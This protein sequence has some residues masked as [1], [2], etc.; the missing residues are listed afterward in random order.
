MLPQFNMENFFSTSLF[1]WGFLFVTYKFLQMTII[2]YIEDITL[3][4]EK[5][6]NNLLKE[7]EDLEKEINNSHKKL[8]KISEELNYEY[9]NAK[10]E[11]KK[12]YREKIVEINE[13]FKKQNK[14][15]EELLKEKIQNQYKNS[16]ISHILAKVKYNSLKDNER[17]NNDNCK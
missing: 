15:K 1:I 11:I 13:N 12:K 7:N 9:K 8:E 10:Y 6:I 14:E 5:K 4:S 2:K 16:N 17:G 3:Y